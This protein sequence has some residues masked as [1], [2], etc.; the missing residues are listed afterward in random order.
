MDSN[1]EYIKIGSQ[2]RFPF[3]KWNR[4]RKSEWVRW[5]NQWMNGIKKE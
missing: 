1:E 2:K 3:E 4:E 5:E